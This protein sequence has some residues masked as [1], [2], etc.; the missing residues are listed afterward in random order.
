MTHQDPPIFITFGNRKGGV[1]KTTSVIN[2]ASYLA[3]LGKKIL[4]VDTDPQS[5]CSS[6]LLKNLDDRNKHS[7]IK[8]LEAPE[9]E[10]LLSRFA[11]ETHHPN[12]QIIPNTTQCML[13]E[14]K[15]AGHSDAVLGIR[16]LINQDPT[17]N[18][19]D[20]VFFDTPP[21]LGVMM[22][23]ALM[24]SDYVIIPIPPSDQFAL[25]GLAAYLELIG[26]IRKHNSRLKL[27]AV[28]ITK[29]DPNWGSSAYKLN[30]IIKYFTQRRISIFRTH[31]HNCPEIDMAHVKRKPVIISAP[32]SSGANEYATLGRELLEI[33]NVIHG[34]R[35]I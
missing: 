18:E 13:W 31:I 23:N 29:Y 8:A 16:R 11:C 6:V 28:L 22:N 26:G 34:K 14:R 19:Y 17:L 5:N 33:F 24:A 4:I 10:G 12:L 20:F 7:L 30:Q 9:G 3:I 1:G 15:N 21:T 27:L 35:F 25:D 2:L 32:N